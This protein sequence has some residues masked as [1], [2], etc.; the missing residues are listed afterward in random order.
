MVYD[1]D[2]EFPWR[3]SGTNAYKA[4]KE[5]DWH[6]VAVEAREFKHECRAA[7]AG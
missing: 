7:G 6:P 5:Q 3:F 2:G 1:V 4:H